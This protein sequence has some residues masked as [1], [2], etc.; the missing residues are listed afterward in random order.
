MKLSIPNKNGRIIE[1][2]FGDITYITGTDLEEID[3]IEKYIFDYFN[4]SKIITSWEELRG[5]E[6]IKLDGELIG[7][8]YFK[9]YKIDGYTIDDNLSNSKNS[10]LQE[11]I[12]SIYDILNL[13]KEIEEIENMLLKIELNIEEEIKKDLIEDIEIES[14]DVNKDILFKNFL[15]FNIRRKNIPV[16]YIG[17]VEKIKKLLEL[18]EKKLERDNRKTLVMLSRPENYLEGF[19]IENLSKKIIDM[20]TKYDIKF[21]IVSQRTNMYLGNIYSIEYI[22]IISTITENLPNIETLTKSINRNYPT[23]RNWNENEIFE[24]IKKIY[25]FLF[26][27]NYIYKTTQEDVIIK[28]INSF[29][30]KRRVN[31]KIKNLISEEIEYLNN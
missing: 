25:T 7:K 15:N 28:I 13:S 16:R 30:R 27:E 29:Y 5:R 14:L 10:L 2:N 23:N 22:N 31:E 21:I 6:Y 26:D 12:S 17:Y 18:L 20:T 3:Y 24:I 1:I 4:S 8:N 19:E 11:Y 9:V